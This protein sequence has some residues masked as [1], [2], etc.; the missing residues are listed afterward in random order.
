MFLA[1]SEDTEA[2]ISSNDK[3]FWVTVILAAI[4]ALEIV[5]GWHQN[6]VLVKIVKMLAPPAVRKRR[7][8]RTD[9][10]RIAD[11]VESEVDHHAD[12]D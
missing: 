11:K 3:L 9:A 2:L 4:T 6:N 5:N 8:A 7:R 10:E 1:L 12:A